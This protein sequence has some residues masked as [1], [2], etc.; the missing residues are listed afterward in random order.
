MGSS[1]GI[2]VGDD[3]FQKIS[4]FR[5]FK[6]NNR[7]KFRFG[8]FSEYKRLWFVNGVTK[9]VHDFNDEQIIIIGSNPRLFSTIPTMVEI[10]PVLASGSFMGT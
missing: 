10:L 5:Y 6:V 3:Q 1:N 2:T 9:V 4:L 7:P 8:V